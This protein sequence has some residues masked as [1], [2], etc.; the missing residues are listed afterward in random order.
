MEKIPR[1]EQE[2]IITYDVELNEWRFYSDY[3]KHI[4]KWGKNVI[5][6]REEFY[7]DGTEK[8]LDGIIN[9][10]VSV[11]G[12]SKMTEEQKKEFA[13]RMQKSRNN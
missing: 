12:R 2:T 8:M 7:Q 4:R 9:G 3:P 5:A 13:S 6:E 1:G 10:T 11:R